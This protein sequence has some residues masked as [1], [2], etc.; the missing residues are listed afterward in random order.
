MKR[1]AQISNLKRSNRLIMTKQ[2]KLPRQTKKGE[3]RGASLHLLRYLTFIYFLLLTAND[4]G[5]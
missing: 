5:S 2:K 3:E 4:K 1:K